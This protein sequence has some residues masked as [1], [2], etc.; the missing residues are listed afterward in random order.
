[1]EEVGKRFGEALA[2]FTVKDTGIP[3]VNNVEAMVVSKSE[4][5]RTLL[6]CC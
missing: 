3:F 2:E 5:I 4:E 1:M 6:L